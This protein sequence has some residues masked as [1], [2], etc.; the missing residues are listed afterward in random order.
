MTAAL[1]NY[2]IRNLYAREL[3]EMDESVL[4]DWFSPDDEEDEGGDDA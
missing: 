3:D 2:P 4:S 1:T